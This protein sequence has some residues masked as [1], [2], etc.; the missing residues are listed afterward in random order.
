MNKL[1][2]FL[3]EAFR[4]FHQLH[5]NGYASFL[6]KRKTQAWWVIGV[7]V[8]AG[9]VM[10]TWLSSIRTEQRKWAT[11]RPIVVAT[12][13]LDAGTALGPHNTELVSIPLALV[14]ADAFD[15]LPENGVTRI[16]VLARTP[17]TVSLVATDTDAA[18]VPEGWRIVA[19]PR[20]LPVPPLRIGDVVDVVGGNDVIAQ[21][22]VVT[23]LDPLTVA[24]PADTVASV[25][26]ASRLGEISV[27][28][29]R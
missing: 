29:S 11:S 10:M 5:H 4:Q 20:S 17:L 3:R 13:D 6:T 8:C 18:Q 27:V 16:A 7:S 12:V 22:A 23:S 26:T 25:A 14:S 9:L 19:L 1:V 15:A 21:S 24:V 2:E 28:V